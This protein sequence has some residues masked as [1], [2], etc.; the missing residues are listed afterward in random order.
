MGGNRHEL[1]LQLVEFA[2]FSVGGNQL[3][4]LF[5]QP[6]VQ[7]RKF[8]AVLRH[9]LLDL[10]H[11]GDVF[12]D[13]QDAVN[14]VVGA[15]VRKGRE[16]E[17]ADLPIVPVNVDHGQEEAGAL[18]A[19]D[20]CQLLFTADQLRHQI[21]KRPA[22]TISTRENECPS[23]F[24]HVDN[25]K[26]SVTYNCVDFAVVQNLLETLIINHVQTICLPSARNKTSTSSP[27][28][29]LVRKY[30]MPNSF[31]AAATSSASNTC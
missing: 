7:Q 22:E 20:R 28:L 23:A 24:T 29:A 5:L 2:Q 27:S 10:S 17:I 8:V 19:H 14:R 16:V 6:V 3:Q 25:V 1:R 13:K 18:S 12:D 11:L 31:A 26:G 21:R 4:I 9:S 15:A 30:G